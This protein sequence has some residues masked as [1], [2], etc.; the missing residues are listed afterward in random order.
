MNKLSRAEVMSLSPEERIIYNKAKT[1]ERVARHRANNREHALEY[2]RTYKKEYV[3]REENR[4]KYKELNRKNVNNH[5]ERKRATNILTNAIK[6]RKARKELQ[7][8]AIEKANKT[9]QE[10]EGN[11]RGTKEQFK[12]AREKINEVKRKYNI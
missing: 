8:I 11:M 9:A 12:E 3:N 1:A 7:E 4:D 10:L 5:F 2:N 6:A